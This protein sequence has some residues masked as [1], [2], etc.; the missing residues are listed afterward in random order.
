MGLLLIMLNK[1]TVITPIHKLEFL[2]N[3]IDNFERQSYQDK[4]L[5]LIVN[6]ELENYK[7]DK[8]LIVTSNSKNIAYVRNLGLEW[9]S[10]NNIKIIDNLYEVSGLIEN[11]CIHGPTMYGYLSELRFDEKYDTMA[12]DI[13]FV[14]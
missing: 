12:E 3:T 1:I 4:E 14:T 9:M 7:N 10:F 5:L 8:Y 13:D 2:Q 11:K 6:G